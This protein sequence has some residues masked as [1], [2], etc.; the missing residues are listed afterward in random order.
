MP[1]SMFGTAAELCAE[2]D[3]KVE[4]DVLVYLLGDT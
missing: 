2:I 4:D 1:D 3:S